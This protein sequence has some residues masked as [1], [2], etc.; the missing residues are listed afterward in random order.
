MKFAIEKLMTGLTQLDRKLENR[1][2]NLI[3]VF[4]EETIEAAIKTSSWH[5]SFATGTYYKYYT[6]I[7]EDVKILS[8]I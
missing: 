8:I 2:W 7:C 3:T 5:S 4:L 1:V 6:S